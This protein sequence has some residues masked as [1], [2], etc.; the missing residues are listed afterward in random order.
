MPQARPTA[1]A[2]D[3][4]VRT[5]LELSAVLSVQSLDLRAQYE[6]KLRILTRIQRGI[7]SLRGPAATFVERRSTVERLNRAFAE[8][9]E[10]NRSASD[11]LSMIRDEFE[12]V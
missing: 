3:N 12:G 8:L 7:E 5:F 6:A 4:D 11:T 2:N 1:A 10:A 9:S